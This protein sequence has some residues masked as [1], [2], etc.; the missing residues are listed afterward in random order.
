MGESESKKSKSDSEGGTGPIGRYRYATTFSRCLFSMVS[1]LSVCAV[2]LAVIWYIW[3]PPISASLADN[4]SGMIGSIV[5]LL[6]MSVAGSIFLTEYL[7]S[8]AEKDSRF[9]TVSEPFT[10]DMGRC[11]KCII[12]LTIFQIV[13]LS[14]A[15]M[16][17]FED[18]EGEWLATHKAVVYLATLFFCTSC[19]MILQFDYDMVTVKKRMTYTSR[20][21]LLDHCEALLNSL[22]EHVRGFRSSLVEE[23]GE[24]RLFFIDRNDDV[25]ISHRGFAFRR[26][27]LKEL[28]DI[29]SMKLHVTDG[30]SQEEGGE[31]ISESPGDILSDLW[32]CSREMRWSSERYRGLLP[33][34]QG[35]S[36]R[37]AEG[38]GGI[39]LDPYKL[40]YTVEYVL[41]KMVNLP[42]GVSISSIHSFTIIN[43]IKDF[44][45]GYPS[46][47]EKLYGEYIEL[48][49]IRDYA[50]FAGVDQEYVE[51]AGS[52]SKTRDK[53]ILS[54]REKD[55]V[56]RLMMFSYLILKND[57]AKSMERHIV[58]GIDL[59]LVDLDGAVMN[60]TVL[61][62]ATIRRSSFC[63]VEAE[64]L[65]I[66][67]TVSEVLMENGEASGLSITES[68]VTGL[69]LNGSRC[70]GLNTSGSKIHGMRA[71]ATT[72]LDRWVADGM[73]LSWLSVDGSSMDHVRF[74][75]CWLVDVDMERA[76]NKSSDYT[77]VT[78]VRGYYRDNDCT[79]SLFM[80]S[81]AD[82][83]EFVDAVYR[84]CRF[85]RFRHQDTFLNRID[86]TGSTLDD[87]YF[88]RVEV[89]DSEIDCEFTATTLS[90]CRLADTR[91]SGQMSEC[92]IRNTAFESGC[93]IHEIVLRGCVLDGVEFAGSE[94]RDVRF[95]DCMLRNVHFRSTVI[96]SVTMEKCTIEGCV[97]EADC[98]VEGL[99]ME[100]SDG[101][102]E[103]R[104]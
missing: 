71:S 37:K 77:G 21:K 104:R 59:D 44:T 14:V 54:K 101:A 50:L 25:R 64:G 53:D 69:S 18:S 84:S 51:K 36:D 7:G 86:A 65:Q 68:N 70:T 72:V 43:S 15:V 83:S 39:D 93:D 100:G 102:L 81:V 56:K 45:G 29:F 5:A 16:M 80:D 28:V 58:E 2:I 6:G 67:G 13:F 42:D 27:G 85:E 1:S 87:S 4:F 20:N 35:G 24:G 90:S 41:G 92:R 31:R 33:K 66:R 73:S 47:G 32:V 96:E 60:R 91:V 8:N 74:N 103:I 40:F 97:A 78:W 9:D 63:N 23:T 76:S 10:A 95:I 30:K 94:V 98:S 61:R 3:D 12:P 22:D 89:R 75:R 46:P 19:C 26:N 48:R 99:D 62:D 17:D 88:E 57:L 52:G 34:M 82:S 49:K 55:A 11:L 38:D 79:F